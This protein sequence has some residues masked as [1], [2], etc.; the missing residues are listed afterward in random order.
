MEGSADVEQRGWGGVRQ[1]GGCHCDPVIQ[2]LWPWRIWGK[3]GFPVSP[4]K[5]K[6][7]FV[8]KRIN[9]CLVCDVQM[10]CAQHSQHCCSPQGNTHCTKNLQPKQVPASP[11]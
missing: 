4:A 3:R 7:L 6:G 9:Q 10:H 2:Q 8:S 1:M 11:P 5:A